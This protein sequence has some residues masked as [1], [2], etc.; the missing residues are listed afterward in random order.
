MTIARRKSYP[1]RVDTGTAAQSLG[2][3]NTLERWAGEAEE[4]RA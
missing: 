4:L 2:G 1:D 3:P